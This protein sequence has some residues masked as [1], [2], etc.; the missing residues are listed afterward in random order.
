MLKAP[1]NFIALMDEKPTY[2]MDPPPGVP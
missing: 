1:I 2:H